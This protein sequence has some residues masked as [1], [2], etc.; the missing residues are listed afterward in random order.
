MPEKTREFYNER[1]ITPH[2]QY[3]GEVINVWQKSE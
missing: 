1:K 2:I 3:I